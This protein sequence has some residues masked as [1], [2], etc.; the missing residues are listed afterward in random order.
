MKTL[1]LLLL[2]LTLCAAEKRYE[3]DAQGWLVGWHE[4][5]ARPNS[6][7]VEPVGIL[8]RRARWDGS[9]W[10]SDASR[11]TADAEALVLERARLR[12]A[13]QRC[14]EFNPDTATAAEVR[15]TLAAALYL[16]RESLRED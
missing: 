16:L 10:V 8:P 9:A 12:A 7:A 14:R 11:E 15:A 2:S 5:A 1:L 4:D 3:Y 13:K 6:T